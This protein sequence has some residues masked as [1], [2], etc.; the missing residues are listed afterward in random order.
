LFLLGYVWSFLG[1]TVTK[2]LQFHLTKSAS[3]ST[4]IDPFPAKI[5]P[6]RAQLNIGL[7]TAIC[8]RQIWQISVCGKQWII[9]VCNSL[10]Q[11]IVG[12]CFND[13]PENA[14]VIT[15]CLTRTRN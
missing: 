15:F 3:K 9:L 6:Y 10:A 1:V 14:A 4:L 7:S 12:D 11:D 5:F 2:W 13:G 8:N